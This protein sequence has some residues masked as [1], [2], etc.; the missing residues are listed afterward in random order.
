MPELRQPKGRTASIYLLRRHVQEERL[1]KELLINL[2]NRLNR[3]SGSILNRGGTG[4]NGKGDQ[5]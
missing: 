5:A 4:D 1:I 3:Q 2:A